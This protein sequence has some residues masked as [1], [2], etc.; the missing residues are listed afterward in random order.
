MHNIATSIRQVMESTTV[1]S[2]AADG[3]IRDYTLQKGGIVNLPATLLHFNPTVNPDPDRFDPKRFLSA[4][5]G[6]S[7]QNPAT[8][9]RP[10][11]GGASYCPGRVFAERQ[12]MGFVAMLLSRFDLALHDD[13]SWEIP[14]TA[15]FNDVAGTPRATVSMLRRGAKAE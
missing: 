2:R 7:G 9:I 12:I 13:G 11:G 8:G 4:D 6:G 10:F 1:T 3:T 14:Q 5:L 15:E